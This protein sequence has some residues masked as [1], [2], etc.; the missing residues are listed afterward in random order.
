MTRAFLTSITLAAAVLLT[1]CDNNGVIYLPGQK[2]PPRHLMYSPTGDPLN[3]G[4]LGYPDCDDAM[5]LWFKRAD[6]NRDGAV[7]A[8]EFVADARAQFQRMN[9]DNTDYLAS[10]EVER[11]RLAYR[12]LS[13]K[14][15]GRIGNIDSA[16]DPVLSA[17]ANLDYKVTRAEYDAF[18]RKTFAGMDKNKD[19]ALQRDEAA[20]SCSAL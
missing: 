1:A 4:A 16:V 19:G 18:S 11:F 15:S 9:A 10:E 3:G 6:A 13:E 5:D 20:A 17:D 8:D 14:K 12:D 2:P 7:T